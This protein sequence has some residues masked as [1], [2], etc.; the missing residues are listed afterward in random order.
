MNRG[1]QRCHVLHQLEPQQ[2]R[3]PQ[4][5][6]THW[7]V[8]WVAHFILNGKHP[9]TLAWVL[10]SSCLH[11]QYKM[12][13]PP[14]FH[15]HSEKWGESL[16]PCS[17]T[18]CCNQMFADCRDGIFHWCFHFDF[19][20]SKASVAAKKKM[21]AILCFMSASYFHTVFKMVVTGRSARYN[22]ITEVF[23]HY[24]HGWAF[25]CAYAVLL[26]L[27]CGPNELSTHFG[28][29]LYL[30]LSLV[31]RSSKTQCNATCE[32]CPN[33]TERDKGYSIWM[34]QLNKA[35]WEELWEYMNMCVIHAGRQSNSNS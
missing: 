1:G 34:Q 19:I 4:G 28:V 16:R 33:K 11:V 30:E 10:P 35:S 31:I 7:V 18:V 24:K 6:K 22:Y 14:V 5:S 21:V 2:T 25:M 32:H 9:L 26:N 29:T 12:P 17:D 3:M 27:I 15:K 13:Y 20:C 23:P 8:I